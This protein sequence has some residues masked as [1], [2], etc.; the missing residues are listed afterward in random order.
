[1]MYTG[2]ECNAP[3]P[4]AEVRRLQKRVKELE[5]T[6]RALNE[7]G[8]PMQVEV[9]VTPELQQQLDDMSARVAEAAKQ[10]EELRNMNAKV[11]RERDDARR[12]R[13]ELRRRGKK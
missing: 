2:N 9:K 11:A 4:A 3:G 12:E 13:D 6:V 1:M 8:A 7:R 5:E 10:N